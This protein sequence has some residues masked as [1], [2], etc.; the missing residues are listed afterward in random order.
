MKKCFPVLLLVIGFLFVTCNSVQAEPQATW[1][2]EW[3]RDNSLNETVIIQGHNVVIEDSEWN[4]S[5][6][7]QKLTLTRSSKDWHEYSKFNDR[8]PFRVKEKNFLLVKFSNLTVDK[9]INSSLYEQFKNLEGARLS[10]DVPGIIQETSA[11]LRDESSVNWTLD[12]NQVVSLAIIAF[13]G[14][15][16]GI[17]FFILG[18]ILVFLVYLRRVKKVDQLI[19]EK[20][21]LQRAAEE[22]ARG[23]INGQE[24][25]N[26][27][28]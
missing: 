11:P 14:V 1:H 13:D 10:I 7:G 26:K 9:A 5:R 3:N 28:V 15:I 24:K 23:E 2:I 8:V 6:S 17:V 20:Y 22:F 27:K 21:S 12:D 25:S 18:F 16:T 4:I 19:A